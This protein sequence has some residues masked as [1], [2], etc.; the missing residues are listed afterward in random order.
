MICTLSPA[1]FME[2]QTHT[3]TSRASSAGVR[4]RGPHCARGGTDTALPRRAHGLHRQDG[5]RKGYHP[6]FTKG[7][8]T[9]GDKLVVMQGVQELDPVQSLS[10][11]PIPALLGVRGAFLWQGTHFYGSNGQGPDPRTGQK[12][13][14]AE[15]GPTFQRKLTRCCA[16]G[17]RPANVLAERM[18]QV[19]QWHM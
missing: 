10:H 5:Q 14:S 6:R 7:T 12:P 8:T 4:R 1:W 2:T 19:T 9:L 18:L 3:T 16:E 13:L 11:K 17:K 15:H